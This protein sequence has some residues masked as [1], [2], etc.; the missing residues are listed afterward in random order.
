MLSR[1]LRRA[2][3]TRFT[4]KR[5]FLTVPVTARCAGHLCANG[6]GLP[7]FIASYIAGKTR[8]KTSKLGLRPQTVS[9]FFATPAR[10]QRENQVV[11]QIVCCTDIP[12]RYAADESVI[13]TG[14][15]DSKL[16]K[17]PPAFLSC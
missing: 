16:Q 14:T 6:F 4:Q 10:I 2:I 8:S 9:V 11:L 12:D 15:S 5:Y 3:I 13:I 7:V 17:V 1:F